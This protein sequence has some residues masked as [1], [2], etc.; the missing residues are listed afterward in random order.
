[1][2][3]VWHYPKNGLDRKTSNE[4]ITDD[5]DFNWIL[6]VLHEHYS[7]AALPHHLIHK[8]HNKGRQSQKDMQ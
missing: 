7:G 8:K 6:Q 4:V 1:M 2:R 5:Q 3:K